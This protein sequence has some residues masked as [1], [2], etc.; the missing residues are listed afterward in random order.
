MKGFNLSSLRELANLGELAPPGLIKSGGTP[1]GIEFGTAEL[2]AVQLTGPET[3]ALVSAACLDTPDE[4]RAEPSRRLAWQ[5]AQLPDL[6]RAAGFKGRRAICALPS[7]LTVCKHMR[8]PRTE[9]VSVDAHVQTAAPVQLE[10]DPSAVVLRHIEVGDLTSGAGAGKTEVICMAASRELVMRLMKSMRNARFEPVGLHSEYQATIKALGDIAVGLDG[11]ARLYVDIG[12]GGSKVIIAHGGKIVFARR[13]ELGGR[14]LDE[15]IAAGGPIAEARQRRLAMTSLTTAPQV[16]G[17]AN[18]GVGSGAGMALL[19]AA[20]RKEGARSSAA[21]ADRPTSLEEPLEI[22]TDDISAC[23]RYHRSTF[24]DQPVE[25]LVFLG[26]ESRHTALCQHVARA[27]GLPAQIADPMSRIRRT[28]SEPVVGVDLTGAQP[29][30]ALPIGLCLSPADL[31][32]SRSMFGTHRSSQSPGGFL[33]EDYLHSRAEKR[34]GLLTLVLFGVVMFG[35]AAAFFV[36]NR[37]WIDVRNEQEAIN[38][39]Y[40]R[41]AQKIEQLKALEQQKAEMLAKAEVTTALIERIPR[42][43]LTAELVTRMPENITLLSMELKSKR[44]M[45][46][47]TQPTQPTPSTGTLTGGGQR[48]QPTPQEPRISAPK[49]EYSLTV[50][51]VSQVNNDIADYLASLK[52]SP[53]LE[54]VDLNYIKPTRISDIELRKFELIARLR[55]DADAR[56]VEPVAELRKGEKVFEESGDDAQPEDTVTDVP[57][58]SGGGN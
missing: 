13:V 56:S 6:V 2:K 29:G 48:T 21:V 9:G 42:S 16:Q 37:Q 45:Q 33:P 27:L 22:L 35:V 26:G 7:A 3:P 44:V 1:V 43:I 18:S 36:T 40:T 24:P 30:W 54:G 38:A 28:G 19:N 57:E 25:S 41:E 8:F 39:E 58:T 12:A 15:A 4:L 55:P 47:P 51:G 53:L 10:C 11:E 34:A 46:R 14:H 31:E 49:Y 50:T 52:N 20:L 32:R 23:L 5:M 17:S